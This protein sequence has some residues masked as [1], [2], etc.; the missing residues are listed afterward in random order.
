MSGTLFRE[1]IDGRTKAVAALANAESWKVD[2][3]NAMFAC[4]VEEFVAECTEHQEFLTKVWADSLQ[5]AVDG[6]IA[7][8]D[9]HGRFL[10]DVISS[11]LDTYR[12]CEQHIAKAIGLGHA[13][14]RERDFHRGKIEVAKIGERIRKQWPIID[15]DE[16]AA[17]LQAVDEGRAQDIETIIDELLHHGSESRP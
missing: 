11:S 4:D 17:A 15:P 14:E 16:V 7:D 5:R 1:R 2:H 12:Q 3:V 9:A 6:R 13:V 10:L 8:M